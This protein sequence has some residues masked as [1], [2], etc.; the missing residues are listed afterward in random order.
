M[1]LLARMEFIDFDWNTWNNFSYFWRVL[2]LTS[3]YGFFINICFL[4]LQFIIIVFTKFNQFQYHL[5][6]IKYHHS[7]ASVSSSFFCSTNVWMVLYFIWIK[8]FI[9]LTRT[10]SLLKFESYSRLCKIIVTFLY[11][12]QVPHTLDSYR[13]QCIFFWT[14]RW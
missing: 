1:L 6:F 12:K 4:Y 5:S 2:S 3:C 11:S 7:N 8:L 9:L 10:S 14:L 13:L